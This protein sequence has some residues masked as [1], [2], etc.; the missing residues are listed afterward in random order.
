MKK[1]NL[2]I[3][4]L[5]GFTARIAAT[6]IILSLTSVDAE[7]QF[8]KLMETANEY[9]DKHSEEDGTP[10]EKKSDVDTCGCKCKSC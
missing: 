6:T 10:E 9:F 7:T 4:E 5:K 1:V 3:E 8:K 2:D